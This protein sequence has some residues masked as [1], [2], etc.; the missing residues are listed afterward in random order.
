[1]AASG[2]IP[3]TEVTPIQVLAPTTLRTADFV[4]SVSVGGAEGVL[5]SHFLVAWAEYSFTGS[6]YDVW[7]AFVGTDGVLAVDSPFLIAGGYGAQGEPFVHYPGPAYLVTWSA[8]RSSGTDVLGRFFSPP[9]ANG[10]NV[11]ADEPI[12]ISNAP[13]YRGWP[14]AVFRGVEGIEDY[15]V[16]WVDD[17]WP[18]SSAL[19]GQRLDASGALLDTD[20]SFNRALMSIPEEMENFQTFGGAATDGTRVLLVWERTG[21]PLTAGPGA[22]G[23]R[24]L[25]VTP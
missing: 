14:A 25:L 3:A 6:S 2:V 4:D 10:L 24:A 8:A 15:L 17:R 7:G 20:A 12:L 16:A 21:Q 13:G 1:V 23:I 5:S 9:V 19:Y 22:A 11:V 18:T